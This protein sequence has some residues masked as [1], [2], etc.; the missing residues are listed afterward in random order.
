MYIVSATTNTAA[1]QIHG[2]TIHSIAGL[3]S[4]LS[5]IMKYGKVNWKLTKLLF[6]DE[7]SMLDVKDFLKSKS[8]G[9]WRDRGGNLG[10]FSLKIR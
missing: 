3:R 10:T 5:N 2:D 7:I 1:A 8:T 4:K 9:H 6:I